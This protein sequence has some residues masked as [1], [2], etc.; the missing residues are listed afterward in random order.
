MP[1]TPISSI[2]VSTATSWRGGE[3][4][5][6]LLAKGLLARGQR[7]L[8][9]AP[10]GAPLLE[11]CQS[12]GIP[13][14]PMR[15]RGDLDF[16][17]A[18]RLAR[19]VK[20][21]K[22]GVLH[23]HDGHAVLPAKVAASLCGKR[24]PKLVV[25]RRTVFPL[26]GRWKYSGRVDRIVAISAAVRDRLQADG[27]DAASIRVVFSGLDFPAADVIAD[28]ASFRLQ[29][30]ISKDAFVVMHAAALTSEKRQ[31]D[32]LR[33][34]AQVADAQLLIAGKGALGPALQTQARELGI[35]ARV[36]FL[37]FVDDLRP[38]LAASDAALFASEAEGLCTALIEAQAAG[39][40]AVITRAG[41]MVEIVE[42]GRSGLTVEIGDIP[43]MAE[44]LCALA[45]EPA[46]R[47]TMGEAAASRARQVF[48][49]GQMVD[50]VLSVYSE[51]MPA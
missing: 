3:N 43:A 24:W 15:I 22:A 30:G 28:G 4:Q 25:H 46:L 7:V 17:G 41:G 9:V 20:R 45:R 29:H 42:H 5:I 19:L 51:L 34:M 14:S 13:A 21:E 47:K 32:I 2:H 40:P 1:H 11:R 33:A 44:A 36:H 8:V 48:S 18:W 38:V 49:A 16:F 31:C 27:V 23:A 39:L 6:W 12:S 35:E 50:G 10:P 26:K 37:G